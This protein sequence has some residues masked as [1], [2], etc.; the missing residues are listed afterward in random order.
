MPESD[1]KNTEPSIGGIDTEGVEMV[2]LKKALSSLYIKPTSEAHFE[3]RFLLDFH[4]RVVKSAV[5]QPVRQRLWENICEIFSCVGGR[6]FAWGSLASFAALFIGVMAMF[7][8]S[9][10][11]ENPGSHVASVRERTLSGFDSAFASLHGNLG[12]PGV[13]SPNIPSPAPSNLDINVLPCKAHTPTYSGSSI[14]IKA[15]EGLLQGDTPV[16]VESEFEKPISF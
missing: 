4:D 10:V 13:L 15:P 6:K 1:T 2:N 16:I 14:I 5:C 3:D 9:H 7:T 8:S 12:S 11:P